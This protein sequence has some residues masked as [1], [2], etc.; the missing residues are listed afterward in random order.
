MVGGS[1]PVFDEIIVSTEKMNNIISF[2][3]DSDVLNVE[4]G[5]ILE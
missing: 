5:V 3:E 2:N 4:S 1:V